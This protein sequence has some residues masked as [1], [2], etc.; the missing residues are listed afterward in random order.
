MFHFNFLMVEILSI[1]FFSYSAYPNCYVFF[2][3]CQIFETVLN[4]KIPLIVTHFSFFVTLQ[5]RLNKFVEFFASIESVVNTK[6][7]YTTIQK[8]KCIQKECGKVC[9]TKIYLKNFKKKVKDLSIFVQLLFK[10]NCPNFYM[11][12]CIHAVHWVVYQI[13]F[14]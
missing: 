2:I 14:N 1:Y 9:I 6:N 5:Y 8:H 11:P 12:F 7:I 13:L 4:P 10:K 3:F